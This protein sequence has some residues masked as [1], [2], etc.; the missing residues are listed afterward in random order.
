MP[1]SWTDVAHCYTL[2]AYMMTLFFIYLNWTHCKTTLYCGQTSND[3]NLANFVAMPHVH[4]C[5]CSLNHF[6]PVL[7]PY[8]MVSFLQW[9]ANFIKYVQRNPEVSLIKSFVGI[10]WQRSW[11]NS[12]HWRFVSN[13]GLY[14]ANQTLCGIGMENHDKFL[15]LQS[16]DYSKS[17]WIARTVWIN[18]YIIDWCNLN[19]ETTT[20]ETYDF[21]DQHI[22]RR[23]KEL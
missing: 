20:N 6:D 3:K 10:Q 21:S 1:P 5:R 23:I 7:R 8:C 9:G 2:R 14:E 11:L 12:C 15:R 22:P 16:S 18:G 19:S 13:T 4:F 17:S